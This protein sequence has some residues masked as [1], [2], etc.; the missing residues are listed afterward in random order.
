[1]QNGTPQ[2]NDKKSLIMFILA[3]TVMGTVGVLRRY[4]P[5]SSAL[6]AF[7]RGAIGS[8]SLLVLVLFL[9]GGHMKKLPAKKLIFLFLSGAFI[10]INWLLLFEAFNYTTVAKAT[11]CYY[12]APTL[13]FL[14]SPIFFK[15]KLTLKKSICAL[16]SI[17]GMVLVSGILES[18]GNAPS[19]VRGIFLA[20]GSAFFYFAVIIMNKLTGEV[21]SYQ[22]TVI[23]LAS[24]AI[25]ILP[26]ILLTED[27]SKISWEWKTV[28]LILVAGIVYTGVAYALY[29]ASMKGMRAQ[30]IS[31]LSY[32]DPVVA[33][34]SSAVI[35]GE[36]MTYLGAVGAVLILGSAFVGECEIRLPRRKNKETE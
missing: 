12:L 10:G 7:F 4:I 17:L 28:V 21:D 27:V 13:V 15:E 2:K 16:V 31:A 1:M 26:Y 19:D 35:L 25:V 18:S 36:R 3:L 5:I 14:A 34:F 30:T 23:Q 22:K 24:A 6:L 8:L 29:F 33:L 11:L 20:L 32:I 9:R